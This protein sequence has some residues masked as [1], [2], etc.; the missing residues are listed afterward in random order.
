MKKNLYTV[1]ILGKILPKAHQLFLIPKAVREKKS[2]TYTYMVK[3]ASLGWFT[4]L[5]LQAT[6][7]LFVFLFPVI[8]KTTL[9][10]SVI[11]D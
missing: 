7:F 11:K 1:E 10:K 6:F 4:Y 9:L 8:G 5:E 2:H 3:H